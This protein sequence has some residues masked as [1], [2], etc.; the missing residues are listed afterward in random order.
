MNSENLITIG[1]YKEINLDCPI[2]IVNSTLK[3]YDLECEKCELI[4]N[5][6]LYNYKD[7]KLNL[8]CNK[9]HLSNLN[10]DNYIKKIKNINY[11]NIKEYFCKNCKGKINYYKFYKK[12]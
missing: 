1:S 6:S 5:F 12:Y 10:L 4:P 7:I 8:V 9:G 11:A 3:P 2:S